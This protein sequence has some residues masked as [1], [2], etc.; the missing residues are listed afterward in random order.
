MNSA[1]IPAFVRNT[2][3]IARWLM[4]S[5]IALSD[6]FDRVFL[7]RE[8]R[9]D[10]CASFAPEFITPSLYPGAIVVDVGGGK[11]PAV[12]A[13]QKARLA[14]TVVGIDVSKPELDAAPP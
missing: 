11:W 5:Q 14:L 7:P 10:G 13:A 12:S 9:I 3:R 6:R 1:T 4:N 2:S 8:Y